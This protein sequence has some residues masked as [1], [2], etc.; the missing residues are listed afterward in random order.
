MK[1]L[2]VVLM[3][4]FL[5]NGCATIPAIPYTES[6]YQDKLTEW[7]GKDPNA[8]I[9]SWGPPTSTFD[10]PNGNKMYTW[11]T[12]KKDIAVFSAS[13]SHQYI[14]RAY[15]PISNLLSQTNTNSSS[16]VDEKRF[17]CQ[18]SFVTDKN[19]I[20]GWVIKGNTCLALDFK[21]SSDA[22]R[23]LQF[24][25]DLKPKDHVEL[26]LKDKP[27]ES[28]VYQLISVSNYPPGAVQVCIPTNSIWANPTQDIPFPDIVSYKTSD[29]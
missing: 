29:K 7:V 19:L 3:A 26:V 13:T 8:L 22:Q 11:L 10:M 15:G 18:T 5:L 25:S 9:L 17:W 12:E 21:N 16:I 28:V 2:V 23:K 20:V 6:A 14:N 4:S 27:T 24:F 1:R